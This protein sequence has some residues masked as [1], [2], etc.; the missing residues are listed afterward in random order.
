MPVG[1]DIK[2]LGLELGYRPRFPCLIELRINA[3]AKN[4]FRNLF[5]GKVHLGKVHL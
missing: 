3:L 1:L 2:G 4:S 5:L